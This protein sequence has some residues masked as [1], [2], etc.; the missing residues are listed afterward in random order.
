MMKSPGR[1][2]TATSSTTASPKTTT[3]TPSETPKTVAADL[4]DSATSGSTVPAPPTSPMST[5]TVTDPSSVEASADPQAK[6]ATRE[7]LIREAAY[8]RFSARGDS[9]DKDHLQ[10]WFE[11]EAEVDGKS[12]T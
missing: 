1:S 3:S 7:E 12:A 6:E 9:D 11:A 2:E 5:S 4:P 10:D 8:R